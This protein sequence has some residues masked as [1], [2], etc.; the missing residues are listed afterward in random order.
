[1]RWTWTLLL[2]LP[3]CRGPAAFSCADDS[4][5]VSGGALGTCES[6]GFCSF[7]DPGCDSGKKYGGH[8]G[9]GL[10]GTC[11]P[12]GDVTT[13]G[14]GTTGTGTTDDTLDPETSSA[15]TTAGTTGPSTATDGTTS[16]P[17]STTGEATTTTT[18][19]GTTGSTGEQTTGPTCGELGDACSVAEDCCNGCMDCVGSQCVANTGA[20]GPCGECMACNALAECAIAEGQ[21]CGNETIDCSEKVWGVAGSTCYALK[22][23]IV[24]SSCNALGQCES[25]DFSDCPNEQGDDLVACASVCYKNPNNCT[26]GT[27]ANLILPST[28]C[29]V[30]QTTPG[31]DL[32]CSN[33]S[34]SSLTQ[35]SCTSSGQ[36]GFVSTLETCDPYYCENNACNT[37]CV[38]NGD[39]SFFAYCDTM[40]NMCVI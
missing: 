13:T 1:M 7:P 28:V 33:G 2:L 12:P 5:C 30:N 21:A 34:G 9:G 16:G 15:P 17:V 26:P 40:T 11:V 23:N 27:D 29:L 24:G 10:G 3:A 36:C 25:P 32:A 8:A 39:C 38:D 35:R 20:P 6:S 14:T 31:C 19:G 22:N 37:S 4:Q 18:T